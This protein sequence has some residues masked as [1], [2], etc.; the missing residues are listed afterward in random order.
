M[1][2]WVGA[3]I[4]AV[5]ISG[6]SAT[7]HSAAAASRHATAQKPEAS[8]AM[9]LSARRRTHHYVSRSYDRPHYDDRPETYRLYPYV[10]PAPFPFGL[11]FGPW[12]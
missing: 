4:L 1:R 11:G 9:D 6:G 8:Q 7:I 10:L 5:L 2:R 12:W 3:I